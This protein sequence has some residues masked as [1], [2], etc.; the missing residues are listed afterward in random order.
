MFVRYMALCLGGLQSTVK[1]EVE[2][3]ITAHGR[4]R[5]DVQIF[6][7]DFEG[8]SDGSTTF[9][10]EYQTHIEFYRHTNCGVRSISN[11]AYN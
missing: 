8:R 9:I 4:W 5:A 6:Q 3:Q 7:E 1:A 2:R 11:I 10:Q